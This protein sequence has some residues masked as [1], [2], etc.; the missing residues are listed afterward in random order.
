MKAWRI[1]SVFAAGIAVGCASN[2][3]LVVAQRPPVPPPSPSRPPWATAPL[4]LDRSDLRIGTTVHL[5]RLPSATEANDLR[6]VRA[7]AHVVVSLAAWPEDITQVTAL[8]QVPEES[9]VIVI[10]RGYPQSRAA[11]E[12]WNY[13]SARVRLVLLVDGPP[14]S[15]TVIDDLNGMRSLERVIAEMDEPARTGFERLQRPLSFRKILS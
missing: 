3:P 12:L 9:D 11:A 13:L 2:G 8:T 1:A 10:L 4:V 14:P 6:Q 5:S 7:L 15:N